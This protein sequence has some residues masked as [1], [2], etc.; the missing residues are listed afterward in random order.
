[1]ATTIQVS[2]RLVNTLR[3]RKQY[4][5]ESYEEVIWDL[6]EDTM[7]INEETKKEIERARADIKAGKFYTHEQ[8]KNEL[9]L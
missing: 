8:V 6:V 1:M 3:T 4:D 7:E 2:E 5:K 9:G